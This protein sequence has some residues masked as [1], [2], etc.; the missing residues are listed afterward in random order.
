MKCHGKSEITF[1]LVGTNKP[2]D[3]FLVNYGVT[4]ALSAFPL[5]SLLNTISVPVNTVTQNV[6]DT[7]PV[8]LR[9]LDPKRA[10]KIRL[11]DSNDIR[12]LSIIY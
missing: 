3:Q 11:D 4:D 5:H 12:F 2:F 10:V 9:L 6:C 8:L 1:K 7:L